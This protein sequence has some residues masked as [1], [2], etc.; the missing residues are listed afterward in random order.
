MPVAVTDSRAGRETVYDLPQ[1]EKTL[2]RIYVS[3]E[4]TKTI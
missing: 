4:C 3:P 2:M 1:N